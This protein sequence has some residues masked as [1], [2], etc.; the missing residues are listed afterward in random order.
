MVYARRKSYVAQLLNDAAANYLWKDN[1]QFGSLPLSFEQVYA[2]AK[3]AD[4]WINL[5]VLK[6]KKDLL[7]YE[8]RYAEFKAFKTEIS[9]ITR[10]IP[11][12]RGIVTTGKQA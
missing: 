12:P 9:I 5:S 11:M 7:G 1:D 10:G 4:Y 6:H 3:D 2:K 8:S